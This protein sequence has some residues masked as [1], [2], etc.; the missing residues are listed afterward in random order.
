MMTQDPAR[1]GEG[2]LE[3][4]GGRG[5]QD[6]AAVVGLRFP[7]PGDNPTPVVIQQRR[8]HILNDAPAEYAAFRAT[9]HNHIRAWLGVPLIVRDRVIGMLAVDSARRSASSAFRPT[10]TTRRGC[11]K[12]RSTAS[13]E[14]GWTRSSRI[15]ASRFGRVPAKSLRLLDPQP[16]CKVS[17]S[18]ATVVLNFGER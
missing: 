14:C 8:S 9:P 5:W 4:V 11:C 7:V 13:S 6:P 16:R 2:Y 18:H 1:R 15:T 12:K 17:P 10:A 3:I